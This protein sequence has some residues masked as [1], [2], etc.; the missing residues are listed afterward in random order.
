MED[1]RIAPGRIAAGGG[2]GNDIPGA[3]GGK[4]GRPEVHH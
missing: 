3:P 4:G 2:R 1:V